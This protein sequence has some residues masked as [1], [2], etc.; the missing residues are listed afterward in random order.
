MISKHLY[1]ILLISAA[2]VTGC[3]K[4]ELD[5][6]RSAAQ[7]AAAV[8]SGEDVIANDEAQSLN[9]SEALRTVPSGQPQ[10]AAI[11]DDGDDEDENIN[12]D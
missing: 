1:L 12:P 6:P 4:D 8:E 2:I 10:F 11:N 9:P 3:A 7:P 5:E